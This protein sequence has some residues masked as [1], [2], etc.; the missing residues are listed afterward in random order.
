MYFIFQIF[1]YA[2]LAHQLLINI[3]L[4]LGISWEVVPGLGEVCLNILDVGCFEI[5][6]KT[7]RFS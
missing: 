5:L 4:T 3:E 2:N 6:H 1:I 7:L